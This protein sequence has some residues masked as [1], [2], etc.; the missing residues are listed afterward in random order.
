M[1]RLEAKECIGPFF[2]EKAIYQVS[3]EAELRAELIGSL[4]RLY[5]KGPKEDFYVDC[6]EFALGPI[7]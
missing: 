4:I 6:K 3:D 7:E 1:R 5:V 2:T